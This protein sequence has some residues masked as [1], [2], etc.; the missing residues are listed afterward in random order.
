V[1]L[2]AKGASYAST[3]QEGAAEGAAEVV[4]RPRQR[5]K[6]RCSI[7]KLIKHNARIYPKRQA[8]S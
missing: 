4:V 1:L 8:T 7:C 5:V 6:L 2:G 3:I